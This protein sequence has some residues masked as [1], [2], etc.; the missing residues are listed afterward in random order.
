[1]KLTS[2]ILLSLLS[3]QSVTARTVR[4][5]VTDKA[6]GKP[7]MHAR[8]STT[9]GNYISHSN[10]NGAFQ[11]TL[12]DSIKKF[13]IDRFGYQAYVSGFLTS[14][15]EVA[16]KPAPKAMKQ[17]GK[18]RYNTK[19]LLNLVEARIQDNYYTGQV[20]SKLFMKNYSLKGDFMI[21]YREQQA[22][23]NSKDNQAPK[24][25]FFEKIYAQD[26]AK[27][28]QPYTHDISTFLGIQQLLQLLKNLP[29]YQ[30]TMAGEIQQGAKSFYRLRFRQKKPHIE[31]FG[32]LYS[33]SIKQSSTGVLYIDGENFAVVDFMQETK[34]KGDT[35]KNWLYYYAT[36]VPFQE[37]Y[38]L[39]YCY[40]NLNKNSVYSRD[41]QLT[42]KQQ[43]P[44]HLFLQPVT[45]KEA[46]QDTAEFVKPF[47]LAQ[48]LDRELNFF[49]EYQTSPDSIK[50][51]ISE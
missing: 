3:F 17:A 25:K 2:F 21:N 39:E 43:Q 14:K 11:I 40:H 12:P 13:R 27:R 44:M 19:Q 26:P 41:Y 45:T 7:I 35:N 47:N 38:R 10:E 50:V 8:F 46:I 20:H 33:Q 34:Y 37:K 31:R 4:A 32:F 36:F 18:R 5:M 49:V 48:K 9:V 6:T 42:Q 51:V 30:F 15:L 28:S 16:L 29:D 23:V 22:W 24:I 1:M